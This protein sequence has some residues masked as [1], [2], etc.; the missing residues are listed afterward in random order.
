MFRFLRNPSLY[1]DHINNSDK[2]EV[3]ANYSC[4]HIMQLSKRNIII[5]GV[6]AVVVFIVV[7]VVVS[8]S[9]TGTFKA[10]NGVSGLV[11]QITISSC[12]D[13]AKAGYC[14]IKRNDSTDISLTF[15]PGKS[16]S[17][18]EHLTNRRRT[19]FTE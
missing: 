11:D 18:F 10:C 15:T 3:H 17:Y 13:S 9:K 14:E 6:V 8:R 16:K 5:A 12:A 2:S 7:V 19:Q 4:A 1:C